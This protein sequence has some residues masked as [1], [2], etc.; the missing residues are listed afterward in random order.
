[1]MQF[2]NKGHCSSLIFNMNTMILS[3]TPL[4]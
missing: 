3:L 2:G 1:M 4:H